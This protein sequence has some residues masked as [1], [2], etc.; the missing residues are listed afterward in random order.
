MET[1]EVQMESNNK[2]VQRSRRSVLKNMGVGAIVGST[3]LSGASGTTMAASG[4]AFEYRDVFVEKGAPVELPESATEV[5]TLEKAETAVAKTNTNLARL[6]IVDFVKQDKTFSF[7]GRGSEEALHA[8][9]TDQRPDHVPETIGTPEYSRAPDLEQF[10]FGAEYIDNLGS[11]SSVIV[12]LKDD[13]LGLAVQRNS[14]SSKEITRD[15]SQTLNRFGAGNSVGTQDEYATDTDCVDFNSGWDCKGVYKDSGKFEPYGKY[16]IKV[17]C[18]KSN[19]TSDG[20]DDYVVFEIK[21]ASTPGEAVNGWD[22][23][24]ENYRLYRLTDFYDSNELQKMGP[25]STV[26]STQESASVSVGFDSS[27]PTGSTSYS[28][29][30]SASEVRI[31]NSSDTGDELAEHWHKF[32]ENHTDVTDGY[33]PARPAYRVQI[34]EGQS[35]VL[36]NFDEFWKWEDPNTCWGCGDPTY[37]TVNGDGTGDW[38]V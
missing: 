4:S 21:Q 26:G 7:A 3:V 33:Y 11:T 38:Y 14:A 12:P 27:G 34:D 16:E 5:R 29:S 31:E 17:K 18:S 20:N 2:P 37:F 13:S 28:Y 36:Y 30:Y 15:I 6:R 35:Q 22:S 9:L 23:D 32:T 1:V 25:N 24:Y 10:T 19:E 8:V